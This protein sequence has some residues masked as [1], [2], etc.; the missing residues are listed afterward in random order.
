M[1]RNTIVRIAQSFVGKNEADGSFKEIIDLYN[2]QKPLPAGYKMSY[3]DPWC[4]AFVSAVAVKAGATDIIFPECSCD[5]MIRLYQNNFCWKEDDSYIPSPGDIIF[6]DWQDSGIGDNTGGSDHVGIVDSV[7]GNTIKVIEGNSSDRVQ[8]L[9]RTVN[10]RYIR[11]YGLP[12]YQNDSSTYVPSIPSITFP[13]S[14]IVANSKVKVIG[15][16]WYNGQTI[17]D[18]VKQDTWIV[19]CVNGDRV[20]I[21]KNTSNTRSIMS[22]VNIKDLALAD[23]PTVTTPTNQPSTPNVKRYE[24]VSEREIWDY[25]LRVYE[26]KLGVAALMGNLYAESGLLSINMENSYELKLGMNDEMYTEKVDNGSYTNFVNDGVGYGLAQWTYWSRKKALFNYVKTNSY[27]IGDTKAQLEFLVSELAS[28]P[29]VVSAIKSALDIKTP[30]DII[31]VRFENPLDKSDSVKLKRAEYAMLFY[32]KYSGETSVPVVE[33]KFSVG[34]IVNFTGT[35]H[36]VSS[37]LPLGF[38]CQPGKATITS[39]NPNGKHP[40]HLINVRGEGSTV[41]GWVDEGTFTRI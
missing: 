5:R 32:N 38:S 11:G 22:P 35:K 2:S 29:D 24:L 7:I 6:Y 1:D 3:S 41:Y 14:N 37:S 30:S 4:A 15:N 18:W 9:T 31:L 13:D 28:F 39:I 8:Y 19:L 27:S 40:Y 10:Q 25:L 33:K 16:N 12:K 23:Q 21:D 36:Y 26:N 20:V 17:P 34:D